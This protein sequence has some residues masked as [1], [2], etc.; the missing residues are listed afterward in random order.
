MNEDLK[1]LII[2]KY[3]TIRKFAK[4]VEMSEGTIQNHLKDGNWDRNQMV[5]IIKAL[6]IPQRMIYLYFFEATLA[7]TQ[8]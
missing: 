4:V 3:G 8:A 6:S 1:Y 2:A 7:K 5:R